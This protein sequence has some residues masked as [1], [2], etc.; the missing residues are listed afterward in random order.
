[1]DYAAIAIGVFGFVLM[2]MTIRHLEACTISD[3]DWKDGTMG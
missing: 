2:V 1:M 3:P